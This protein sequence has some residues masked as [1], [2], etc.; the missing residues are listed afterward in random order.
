MLGQR[1][2][3][4][5]WDRDHLL[6]MAVPHFLVPFRI[7]NPLPTCHPGGL[8][9]LSCEPLRSWGSTRSFPMYITI[10]CPQ[11]TPSPI[12]PK[13]FP[14]AAGDDVA[15]TSFIQKRTHTYYKHLHRKKLE[16]NKTKQILFAKAQNKIFFS[17]GVKVIK[18]KWTE[19]KA[20]HELYGEKRSHLCGFK[21]RV[22]PP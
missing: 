15:I 10:S 3:C 18:N 7:R 17:K 22:T 19:L 20:T 5:G 16:K 4:W 1:S 21:S 6:E 11:P 9:I 12:S 13:D 2:V 8:P 14:R